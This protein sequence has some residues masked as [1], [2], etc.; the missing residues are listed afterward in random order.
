[1][2]NNNSHCPVMR[3]R[4]LLSASSNFTKAILA[5]SA[6]VL[7]NLAGAQQPQ[8]PINGELIH[9]VN[10]D[11]DAGFG[12]SLDVGS[13]ENKNWLVV[14]Q[15]GKGDGHVT[16]Y[17]SNELEV[18]SISEKICS[19]DS[20][21]GPSEGFCSFWV[22]T[23]D[24]SQGGEPEGRFGHSVAMTDDAS[25]AIVG[26][27]GKEK[28]YMYKRQNNDWVGYG[29]YES[30]WTGDGNGEKF[31]WAVDI[32]KS[33][34]S[35]VEL[36]AVIGAPDVDGSVNS[37]I[38]GVAIAQRTSAGWERVNE[39]EGYPSD[40]ANLG[41]D[42]AVRDNVFYLG[43]PGYQADRGRVMVRFGDVAE[44]STSV[45]SSGSSAG[46]EFG[47]SLDV[48]DGLLIVGTIGPP[49]SSEGG[50][51]EIFRETSPPALNPP[52]VPIWD[53]EQRITRAD[54]QKV[55]I[56]EN[57]ALVASPTG[58]SVSVFHYDANSTSWE[59]VDNILQVNAGDDDPRGATVYPGARSFNFHNVCVPNNEACVGDR[60][61]DALGLS[62]SIAFVGAPY[63]E[64]GIDSSGDPRAPGYD[65]GIAYPFRLVSTPPSSTVET[66]QTGAPG[67]VMI[68]VM[69]RNPNLESMLLIR[70]ANNMP[71]G[72]GCLA[73]P[74]A[75]TVG[76]VTSRSVL[77]P[78]RSRI[79]CRAV[80]P[81]VY[82]SGREFSFA[83]RVLNDDVDYEAPQAGVRE[84]VYRAANSANHTEWSSISSEN[85]DQSTRVIIT[86]VF[87]FDWQLPDGTV[88]D[89]SG[90][91]YQLAWNL[92]DDGQFD[93]LLVNVRVADD[94]ATTDVIEL[95]MDGDGLWD[96]WETRGIDW[97][98]NF[99]I[100]RLRGE[101]FGARSFYDHKDLFVEV[102]YMAQC[103]DTEFDGERSVGCDSD[104]STVFSADFNHTPNP[105]A[106][107]RVKEAFAASPVPNPDGET[108]IRLV[109]DVSDAVPHKDILA[110][111]DDPCP[112]D[113]DDKRIS[114]MLL[115]EV[116]ARFFPGRSGD[117]LSSY[118]RFFTHRYMVNGHSHSPSEIKGL[119][120]DSP[121]LGSSGGLSE[122]PGDDFMVTRGEWGT[123]FFE[124]NEKQNASNY[125]VTTMH[126]FGHALSLTHGGRTDNDGRT[127]SNGDVV[128][129]LN[130]K[131][132]YLS[133]M[134]YA[135]SGGQGI[136]TIV[137][138]DEIFAEILD[139]SRNALPT[140]DENSLDEADGIGSP[141][142]P[143]SPVFL[144][145]DIP[146]GTEI[147][148]FVTY[149]YC[150]QV[151]YASLTKYADYIDWDCDEELDRDVQANINN[152][153]EALA[154][155][156]DQ[157]LEGYDDWANLR[158]S[159]L[160][161]PN[162]NGSWAPGIG[163]RKTEPELP[164]TLI[165][166]P[167]ADAGSIADG[168]PYT[169]PGSDAVYEA[170]SCDFG[171]ST[172]LDGSGSFSSSK[173][174]V[175]HEWNFL[176]GAVVDASGA[177]VNYSC[178][179][180]VGDVPVL[181]TVTDEDGAMVADS[182]TVL[183]SLNAG[184][185]ING[186]CA[187]PVTVGG[188][189]PASAPVT[190]AW[191]DTTGGLLANTAS[192]SKV[193][194]LG[195]NGLT[196]SVTDNRGES[197]TDGLSVLVSDTVPPDILSVEASRTR[198]WPPNHR[199]STIDIDILATDACD[200]NVQ[201]RVV[202]VTSNEADSGT[203]EEDIPNDIEIVDD[204]TIRVRQER[205]ENGTGRIYTATVECSDA[206][207]GNSAQRSVTIMVPH[208]KRG[209]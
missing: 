148:E 93:D 130:Y 150:D 165:E 36:V 9:D 68:E 60:F 170:Y 42:V 154:P 142:I 7:G 176:D 143:D 62:S 179:T 189:L 67:T 131:P 5:L 160:D 87:P 158:L 136:P 94:P 54:G 147:Y 99:I 19:T 77:E 91:V 140:L 163:A 76:T 139:Y 127:D 92:D 2:K 39:F 201:C 63:A 194:P 15:P 169:P 144:T 134:N 207:G 191:T 26:A 61:G 72:G 174:I 187:S 146:L 40:N 4:S 157:S 123:S 108:G 173:N 14:G 65:S 202:N 168:D 38:G 3:Y 126:E 193:F 90:R 17:R 109:F 56:K 8:S 22:Q 208:D 50:Y 112:A 180:H 21:C 200:Q 59:F 204:T 16:F 82:A 20:D 171:G 48:D 155:Y 133:V 209:K 184:P 181:L 70:G 175:S 85:S 183:V 206:T 196:A 64:I 121:E 52:T 172:N 119:S 205:D 104:N 43:E 185:D 122:L 159:F 11:G 132:N 110:P 182:G 74:L 29:E 111:D 13:A 79:G 69:R 114:C 105:A 167:V 34:R 135:Y 71:I 46:D 113:L 98:G 35:G 81:G 103:S 164:R 115:S 166:A 117:G 86:E 188:H 45:A 53:F 195:P 55:A 57:V 83:V 137:D 44:Y 138:S 152:Q 32:E 101:N 49:N 47:V 107:D 141:E 78:E 25:Y 161:H 58:N 102:D 12:L 178:S 197:A 153:S 96:D 186:E 145:E 97:D 37:N 192:F 27:P 66:V 51:A 80:L 116:K 75:E 10:G 106:L 84:S 149:Y 156:N 95:D 124:G 41:W 1:M 23:T 162:L 199:M 100:D 120:G 203:N 73:D 18:C 28:A 30:P 24:D 33:T 89:L 129:N 190:Y 118:A 128:P 88:L 151:Q 125:A 31:G 6:L 177:L 198:L